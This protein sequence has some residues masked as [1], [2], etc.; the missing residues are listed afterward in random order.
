MPADRPTRAAARY[1]AAAIATL[2]YAFALGAAD[3]ETI[4]I[5]V[6]KLATCGPLAI[7]RD[8]GYFAAEGLTPDFVFFDA[9]QPIAVAVASGDLDFGIAAPT[10]AL[11]SL[12]GQGTL[13]IIGGGVSEA[14]TFHYLGFSPPTTPTRPG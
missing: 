11:Y 7:A 14:P 13:R 12:A 4:K 9:Q 5:G 1:A 10:A 6:T 3:A 8:K 2:V